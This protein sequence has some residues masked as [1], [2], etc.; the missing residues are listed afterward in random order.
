[1]FN[2]VSPFDS[3]EFCLLCYGTVLLGTCMAVSS[4]RADAFTISQHCSFSMTTLFV[5]MSATNIGTS[6][7][8][9]L[10]LP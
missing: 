10:V 1:M 8:S 4:Q 7:L 5:Q 9:Q 3:L 6:A 2:S